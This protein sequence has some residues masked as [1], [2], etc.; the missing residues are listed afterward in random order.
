MKVLMT[1]RRFCNY[2]QEIIFFSRF[3]I[4][5]SKVGVKFVKIFQD[6]SLSVH[7]KKYHP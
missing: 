5:K 2:L 6:F 4:G 7:M 1:I 3:F